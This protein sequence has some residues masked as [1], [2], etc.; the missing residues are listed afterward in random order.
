M[1]IHSTHRQG[2][3]CLNPTTELSGGP[4]RNCGCQWCNDGCEGTGSGTGPDSGFG[5]LCAYKI[6]VECNRHTTLREK[7]AVPC[8]VLRKDCPEG[9]TYSSRWRITNGVDDPIDNIDCQGREPR[10]EPC[11]CLRDVR[12]QCY[13]LTVTNTETGQSA[14]WLMNRR[15]T[16]R[17]AS[18]EDYMWY[19]YAF[20]CPPNFQFNACPTVAACDLTPRPMTINAAEVYLREPLM[21]FNCSEYDV[22]SSPVDQPGGFAKVAIPVYAYVT[23]CGN[24]AIPTLSPVTCDFVDEGTCTDL[25]DGDQ[26]GAHITFTIPFPCE[27]QTSATSTI[28]TLGTGSGSGSTNLAA[29]FTATLEIL[30]GVQCRNINCLEGLTGCTWNST[31]CASLPEE[32]CFKKWILDITGPTTATLTAHTRS[33]HQGVWT[34]NEWHCYDRSTFHLVSHDREL[35]GIQACLCVAPVQMQGL[36]AYC[37]ESF[38]DAGEQTREFPLGDIIA[39]C[40]ANNL[41][42]HG[43]VGET[44]FALVEFNRGPDLPVEVE[45][46][47][48]DGFGRCNYFWKTFSAFD[49]N[50]NDGEGANREIGVLILATAVSDVT[51]AN[52]DALTGNED[53]A[54]IATLYCKNLETGL[55][56]ER[57]AF[58]PECYECCNPQIGVI[59]FSGFECCCDGETVEV[60]CCE[61]V[62][63]PTTL[64]VEMTVPG[65]GAATFEIVWDADPSQWSGTYD[66]GCATM[67]YKLSCDEFFGWGYQI[68]WDSEPPFAHSN[69][70]S[71]VSC[72]PLLINF[73]F[74]TGNAGTQRFP[75]CIGYTPDDTYAGSVSL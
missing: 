43:P 34:T 15:Y 46:E 45:P 30:P 12:A 16:L 74:G 60:P 18:F 52:D 47:Q 10:P 19:L 40:G 44:G 25:A 62:Q 57:S 42:F 2:C 3:D 37:E 6:L 75:D 26:F 56:E 63:L 39:T 4:R 65:A 8:T 38:C 35:M 1:P 7:Y 64:T 5:S 59:S 27:G 11:D 17:D 13:R 29:E 68:S 31:E 23:N 28:C 69:N 20:L 48:G 54:L 49:E 71:L 21:A 66:W 33:G 73:S 24:G 41:Y 32:D 67:T 51:C 36:S 58:G 53:R 22:P 61:G 55:F 70:M 50:C 9:C 14:E 72:D